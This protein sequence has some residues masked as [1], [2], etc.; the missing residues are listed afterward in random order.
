[1]KKAISFCLA[2]L[3]V[4]GCKSTKETGTED[5]CS[6]FDRTLR[7]FASKL[8]AVGDTCNIYTWDAKSSKYD[9]YNDFRGKKPWMDYRLNELYYYQHNLTNEYLDFSEEFQHCTSLY[10]KDEIIEIFGTTYKYND[11]YKRLKY[12]ICNKET[13]ITLNHLKFSLSS[14]DKVESFLISMRPEFLD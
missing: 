8:V 4:L 6:E 11:Y 14:D 12:T 13:Q 1:M 5:F 9:A 3:V 7:D 10:T 2:L